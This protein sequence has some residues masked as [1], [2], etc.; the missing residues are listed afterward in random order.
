MSSVW[1]GGVRYVRRRRQPIFGHCTHDER[2]PSAPRATTGGRTRTRARAHT[3]TQTHTYNLADVR[4]ATR[5]SVGG[6]KSV[7]VLRTRTRAGERTTAVG[8]G[9]GGRTPVVDG[10][11]IA[12]G[13]HGGNRRRRQRWQGRCRSHSRFLPVSADSD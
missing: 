12:D 3:L 8:G 9:L 11:N 2:T 5:P 6:G 7:Y 1:R 13:R 4:R 10:R